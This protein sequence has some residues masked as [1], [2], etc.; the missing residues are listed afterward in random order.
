VNL[1]TILLRQEAVEEACKLAQDALV[2]IN[3]SK[4]P[5]V[6]LHLVK[7]K[8]KLEPWKTL[9]AVETFTVDFLQTQTSLL[10]R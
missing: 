8:R 3:Q 10:K 2:L 6:L 5:L 1:A 7:F 4:S 9:T